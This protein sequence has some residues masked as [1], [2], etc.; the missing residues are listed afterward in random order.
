MDAKTKDRVLVVDDHPVNRMILAKMLR[1]CGMQ[2]E[3]ASDGR[4]AVQK[5]KESDYAVVF[6]DCIMPEWDGVRTAKEIRALFAGETGPVLVA[7]SGEALPGQE[8]QLKQNGVVGYLQKPVSREQLQRYLPTVKATDKKSNLPEVMQEN[9]VIRQ[10]LYQT[11]QEQLGKLR[12][13]KIEPEAANVQK[14]AA[15]C[16]PVCH[17]LKGLMATVN[18]MELFEAFGRLLQYLRQDAWQQYETE[19]IEVLEGAEGLLGRMKE[20]LEQET[21]ET[22]AMQAEG[23][24]REGVQPEQQAKSENIAPEQLEELLE[25][26]RIYDYRRILDLLS[27]L[28]QSTNLR[29][30]QECRRLAEQFQYGASQELLL[31]T[32]KV[33]K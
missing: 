21:S 19:S 20:Q 11:I 25:A 10:S 4:S 7:I 15:E 23:A 32:L 31:K 14:Q 29:E 2:V 1:E 12:V 6:L 30:L 3:E 26:Y 27:R 17:T 13:L 5:V 9:F 8:E 28:Q 24:E 16:I 33:N 18:E 22:E